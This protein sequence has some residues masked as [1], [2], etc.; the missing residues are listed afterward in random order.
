MFAATTSNG[1]STAQ[2]PT[3]DIPS[4]QVVDALYL[5]I[6]RVGNSWTQAY[7]VDGTTWQS[8]Q[9]FEHALT[10]NK[11][12]IFAANQNDVGSAPDFLA[13]V[14]F[15]RNEAYPAG[16]GGFILDV[17][18]V[19]EGAVEL[20]PEPDDNGG[21][22]C[23]QVVQ[24]QAVPAADFTGWSGALTGKLNP[25]TI[26][27]NGNKSVTAYFGSAPPVTSGKIFLP[28]VTRP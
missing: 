21:Y 13:S 1:S 6:S 9:T 20:T 3:V 15:F 23:N 8:P 2:K 16:T 24:L 11:T 25:T 17:S 18:V 5:R 7:S 27:M 26:T 4:S 12:G 10:V 28:A 19:G 22:G 14:D